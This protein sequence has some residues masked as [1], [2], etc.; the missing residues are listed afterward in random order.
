[1]FQTK[2]TPARAGPE[3]SAGPDGAWR[4]LFRAG[5]LSAALFVVLTLASIVAI[6]ITGLPSGGGASTL[7]NA[8]A[9]LRYIDS[10]R[11][12][13]IIDELLIQGPFLLTICLFMALYVALRQANRSW[14][15]I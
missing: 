14:A 10:N 13:F 8:A 1:V 2:A 3:T 6:A 4:T 7:P 5:A 11:W 12:A 15:A 9:T